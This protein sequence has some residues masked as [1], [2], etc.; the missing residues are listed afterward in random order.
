MSRRARRK[1]TTEFK[2]EAVALVK[3]SGKTVGQVARELDLTETA[4][5]VWVAR[6]ESA[7]APRGALNESERDELVRLRKDFQRVQME[8]DFLKKAA[9]FFARESK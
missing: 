6:F 8:R 2:A 3:K 5:R 9:A 7:S 4:L 1:F